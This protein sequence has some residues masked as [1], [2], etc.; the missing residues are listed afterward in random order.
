MGCSATVSQP[1]GAVSGSRFNVGSSTVGF[2]AADAAGNTVSCTMSVT[3]LDAEAPSITCPSSGSTL[4]TAAGQCSAPWTYMVSSNDNCQVAS[5]VKV[6]GLASGDS[7]AVGNSSIKWRATDTVGL[8]SECSS[9]V[10]VADTERPTITCPSDI[11]VNNDVGVCGAAVTY[12]LATAQD[13]CGVS[14]LVVSSGP[15]SGS[16]FNVGATSLAYT[17]SDSAGNT[18]TCTF[19]VTVVDVERPVVTCSANIMARS[20]LDGRTLSLLY[21]IDV[22]TEHVRVQYLDGVHICLR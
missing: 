20:C 5:T 3:V 15:I 10:I 22:R 2:S 7:F 16:V 18:A 14:S 19:Q 17:A 6:S 21:S 11:T 1:I 9:W 8:W 4:N 13:N 12:G